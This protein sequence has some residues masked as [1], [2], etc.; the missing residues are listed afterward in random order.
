MPI[1]FNQAFVLICS[2]FDFFLTDSLQ[3]ITRKQ[4]NIL[5]GLAGKK[6]I[7]IAQ[8]ID[9]ANYRKIFE[10]IQAKVLKDF[11]YGSIEHKIKT[12]EKL[13]VDI[14]GAF[15]FYYHIHEVQA[16]Y[17]NA[18]KLLSDIYEK[19]HGVVHRDELPIAN[20][21]E[22]EEIVLFLDS[23]MMSLGLVMGKHFNIPT[24]VSLVLNGDR[25]V[26]DDYLDCTFLN[27]LRR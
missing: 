10:F 16:K 27:P 7:D 22:L 12:I 3:V 19:R 11:D 2:I 23:L 25:T 13:K 24:D 15:S 21:D 18:R 17:P 8:V 1:L 26:L 9:L 6:E 5:K 4:P 20:Y 14:A